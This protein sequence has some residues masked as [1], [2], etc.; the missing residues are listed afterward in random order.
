M[1]NSVR[2]SYFHSLKN[3]YS[4]EDNFE[5]VITIGYQ[6]KFEIKKLTNKW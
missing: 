6:L 3:I 5:K 4:S 2:Y 1:T